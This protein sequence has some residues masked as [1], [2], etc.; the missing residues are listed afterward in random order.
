[1][2]VGDVSCRGRDEEKDE[3]DDDDGPSSAPAYGPF[4]SSR[5]RRRRGGEGLFRIALITAAAAFEVMRRPGRIRRRRGCKHGQSKER[6]CSKERVCE[7]RGTKKRD[8]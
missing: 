4:D 3:G 6:G 5:R 1:V 8:L 2:W 7:R